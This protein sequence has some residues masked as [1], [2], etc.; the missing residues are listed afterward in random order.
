MYLYVE[1]LH[2]D[3]D[4]D[5]WFTEPRLVNLDHAGVLSITRAGTGQN[6]EPL[7][8][9]V[10]FATAKA[11]DDYYFGPADMTEDEQGARLAALY[12]ALRGSGAVGWSMARDLRSRDKGHGLSHHTV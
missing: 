7:T 2:R 3:H 8:I 4:D 6:N 5:S 10:T 1:K 11:S 12:D 9:E